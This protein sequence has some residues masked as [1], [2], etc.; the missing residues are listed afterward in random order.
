M[1]TSYLIYP[2]VLSQ[3]EIGLIK[4]HILAMQHEVISR[5]I[6]PNIYPDRLREMCS[7][8][9]K[10]MKEIVDNN[11][12]EGYR[13]NSYCLNM[14]SLKLTYLYELMKKY[15]PEVLKPQMTQIAHINYSI[16]LILCTSHNKY[17]DSF[18]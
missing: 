10:S 5:F 8:A 17:L 16:S 1:N 11:N 7:N 14:I 15:D 2:V 13:Y 18:G 3:T 9:T 4:C 12:S 6:Q